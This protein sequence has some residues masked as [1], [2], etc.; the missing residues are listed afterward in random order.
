M[1]ATPQDGWPAFVDQDGIWILDTASA[2]ALLLGITYNI[3]IKR[4]EWFPSANAQTLTIKDRN[5]NERVTRTSI[6][7]SPAGDEI[8]DYASDPLEINGFVLHTMGGGT[9]YVYLA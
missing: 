2:T 1:P 8:M 9:L 6:A 5:G 3:K 4:M 7:A